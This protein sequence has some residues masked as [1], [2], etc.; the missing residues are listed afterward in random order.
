MCASGN[1][2]IFIVAGYLSHFSRCFRVR[3]YIR[4]VSSLMLH[5][6]IEI[7]YVLHILSLVALSDGMQSMYCMYVTKYDEV[8]TV[9]YDHQHSASYNVFS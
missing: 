5:S 1:G 7:L 3:F 6:P 8:C 2:V 4:I 9:E